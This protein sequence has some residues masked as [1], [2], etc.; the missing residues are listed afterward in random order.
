MR[1]PT[2][3]EIELIKKYL[4]VSEDDSDLSDR[5]LVTKFIIIDNLINHRFEKLGLESLEKLASIIPGMPLTSDH[6]W[7][8][9]SKV[10]ATSI[11]AEVVVGNKPP[12]WVLE[13]TAQRIKETNLKVLKKEGYQRIE[14]LFYFSKNHP[15]VNQIKDGHWKNISFG[16]LLEPDNAKLCPHCMI[17][18]EDPNC[19]HLIPDSRLTSK[20]IRDRRPDLSDKEVEDLVA[21]IA[22]YILIT[23]PYLAVESSLVL[24]PCYPGSGLL[25]DRYFLNSFFTP[26]I[27]QIININNNKLNFNM[28]KT[29][30]NDTPAPED[31]SKGTDSKSVE[32]KTENTSTNTSYF[33]ESTQEVTMLMELA[34]RNVAEELQAKHQKVVDSLSGE[35]N[36]IKASLNDREIGYKAEIDDLQKS[37]KQ[38]QERFN[39]FLQMSKAGYIKDDQLIPGVTSTSSTDKYGLNVMRTATRDGFLGKEGILG[40][41]RYTFDECETFTVQNKLTG[42]VYKTHNTTPLDNFVKINKERICNDFDEILGKTGGYDKLVK[43]LN[44][45]TSSATMPAYFLPV[46]SSLVRTTHDTPFVLQQFANKF[47]RL[48]ASIGE[49]ILVPRVAHLS[50]GATA[51]DYILNPNKPITTGVDSI[52]ATNAVITMQEWG[53][54]G[55]DKLRPIGIPEFH[56]ILTTADM[57]ALVNDRLLRDYYFATE[58]ALYEVLASTTAA[59]YNNGDTSLNNTG[60]ATIATGGTMSHKFLTWLGA[61]M[62]STLKIPT[63]ADGSYVL[64][65]NGTA[66]AQLESSMKDFYQVSS[67]MELEEV[68]GLFN[69]TYSGNATTSPG[70]QRIKVGMFLIYVDSHFGSGNPGDRGVQTETFAT[71]N[72]TTRTSFAFG[73]NVMACV[74]AKPFT[75]NLGSNNDFGRMETYTWQAIRGIGALDVDPASVIT[76]NDQQLRVLDVRTSDQPVG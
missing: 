10:V 8:D 59:V 26:N 29:Q 75:I 64:V 72:F 55:N 56:R 71:G 52:N 9:S 11:S 73:A 7:G 74:D 76:P 2:S 36:E 58:L 25:T 17:P 65:L 16:G 67:R 47:L 6:D 5:F 70:F 12:D 32:I 3:N 37:L 43:T 46:L 23:T 69:E 54:G 48:D 19:P 4:P 1:S 44:A 60:P 45:P 66:L 40:A 31:K 34:K 39:L 68:T 28:D 51:A 35:L 22:D 61:Y 50:Q 33:P 14:A 24:N 62:Y 41:L 38:Q 13:A 27:E 30:K 21:S 49:N 15:V 53:R 63:F 20:T 57:M 18:F 42:H